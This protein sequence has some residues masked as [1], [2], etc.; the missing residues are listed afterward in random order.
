MAK[1]IFENPTEGCFVAETAEEASSLAFDVDDETLYTE[2]ERVFTQ[3][4]DNSELTI[5]EEDDDASETTMTCKEWADLSEKGF[6]CR[7]I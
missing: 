1:H 2:H 6:L 4:P 7:D 5:E 3:L